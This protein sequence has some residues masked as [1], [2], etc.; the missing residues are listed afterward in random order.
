MR[1]FGGVGYERTPSG[2]DVCT[3]YNDKVLN[4]HQRLRAL[5]AMRNENAHPDGST[6]GANQKTAN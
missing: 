1:S 3:W 6:R 2:A 4:V 5:V